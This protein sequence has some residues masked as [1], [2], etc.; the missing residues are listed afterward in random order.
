[1]NTEQFSVGSVNLQ[2]AAF[3]LAL[4]PTFCAFIIIEAIGMEFLSARAAWGSR[5]CAFPR[6]ML[7]AEQRIESFNY[8]GIFL[9]SNK[10]DSGYLLESM[11]PG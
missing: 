11:F 5:G 1:M 6:Q 9:Q 3:S 2:K 10:N 4:R 7:Y 8:R